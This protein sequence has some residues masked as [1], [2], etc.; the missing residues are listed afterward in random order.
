MKAEY[1]NTLP[2]R[3]IVTYS[4]WQFT[5]LYQNTGNSV[6]LPIIY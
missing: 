1:E 6:S 2:L 5:D 3:Q 4:K